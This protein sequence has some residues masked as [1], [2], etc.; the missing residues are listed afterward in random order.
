MAKIKSDSITVPK[1]E[2]QLAEQSLACYCEERVP[3]HVRDKVRL[4]Y[5]WRGT[6]TTNSVRR[7]FRRDI[8][9]KEYL[10]S[11]LK[12]SSKLMGPLT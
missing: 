2:K 10:L 5:R 1:D 3:A 7:T 8:V 9:R 12:S 11:R 6:T 4:T